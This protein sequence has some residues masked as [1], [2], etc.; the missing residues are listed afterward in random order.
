MLGGLKG[1][2]M[3]KL[4][5]AIEMSLRPASGKEGWADRRSSP[6]QNSVL[7][8]LGPVFCGCS[9]AGLT[10]LARGLSKGAVA[11]AG[12]LCPSQGRR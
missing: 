6:C 12:H 9:Q 8:I 10:D 2:S 3:V 7:N 1:T 4:V 5:G 11:V